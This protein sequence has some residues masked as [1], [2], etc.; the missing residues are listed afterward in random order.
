MITQ[1]SWSFPRSWERTC[2]P[3]FTRIGTRSLS[4]PAS[5]LATAIFRS[6]VFANG[7]QLAMTLNQVNREGMTT[8]PN[9]TMHAI[10]FWVA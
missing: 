4:Y 5:V 6:L 1:S 3:T 8:R 10:T 7:S 9:R 2:S